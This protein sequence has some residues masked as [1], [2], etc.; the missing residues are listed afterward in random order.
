[1]TVNA[2][3]RNYEE[4]YS[5]L[6]GRG[7]G[8]RSATGNEE[9]VLA[10]VIFEAA[11]HLFISAG[12]DV[13]YFPWLKFRCS[14]PSSGRKQEVRIKYLPTEKL[15]AEIVYQYRHTIYDEPEASGIPEQRQLITNS[16]KGSVRYDFSENMTLA[17]RIDYKLVD[18]SESTGALLSQ[19]VI[20]KWRHVP[21]T[22]WFRYCLFHTDDWD[23]R[24]YAYEND[25]LY[26]FSIPALSGKGSRS[27]IMGKW[28]I[29]DSLEM[30][31]KYGITS[32]IEDN[33]SVNREE[34]KFQ[35]KIFF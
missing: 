32:L 26:S 4:G 28:E 8:M 35:V 23:S 29:S 31:V 19:D 9:G 2:L 17:T 12:A 30:R 1:M 21:V 22:L 5:A 20:Y 15:R 11:K 16:L 34:I 10:N 6:H 24:L 13:H 18:P 3:Y 7:P 27:Y 33:T 14:S 25:L